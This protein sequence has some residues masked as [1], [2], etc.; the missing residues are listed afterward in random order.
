[1]GI[2]FLPIDAEYFTG[3]RSKIEMPDQENRAVA[4]PEGPIP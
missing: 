1:L 2:S 4:L 3:L